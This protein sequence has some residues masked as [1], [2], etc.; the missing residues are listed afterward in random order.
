MFR[1]VQ[2]DQ[3]SRFHGCLLLVVMISGAQLSGVCG[4]TEVR[5]SS[6]V[7][8]GT[9]FIKRG[10]ASGEAIGAGRYSPHLWTHVLL[11]VRV[12]HRVV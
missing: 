11:E 5:S 8:S 6:T 9:A 3:L 2:K 1:G 12:S 10:E 4:L 7:P